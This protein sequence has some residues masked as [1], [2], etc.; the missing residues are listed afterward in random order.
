MMLLISAVTAMFLGW[1]KEGDA[2]NFQ[3]V[4]SATLLKEKTNFKQTKE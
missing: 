2:L 3:K 4:F 1:H